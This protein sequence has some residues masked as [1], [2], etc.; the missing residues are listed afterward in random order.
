MEWTGFN[1]AQFGDPSSTEIPPVCVWPNF[2]PLDFKFFPFE[3]HFTRLLSNTC[4]PSPI[5]CKFVAVAGWPAPEVTWWRGSTLLANHSLTTG[6]DRAALA[7]FPAPPPPSASEGQV[8]TELSIPALTRDY[9]QANLTCR[10][11][12]NN[13]TAPLTT[14]LALLVYR[15]YQHHHHLSSPPPPLDLT[16]P[17]PPPPSPQHYYTNT[18][19]TISYPS[20]NTTRYRN[21]HHRHHSLPPKSIT[22]L[23]PVTITS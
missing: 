10:A 6:Y 23:P 3:N 11:A 7:A 19:N 21:N 20:I 9:V 22:H 8:R 15:E 2:L 4:H 1:V 13:I 5:S 12:N 17:Q 16:P 14:S 18:T